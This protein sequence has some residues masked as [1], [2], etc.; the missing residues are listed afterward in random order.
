MRIFC[1]MLTLEA[2]SCSI[3]WFATRDAF[4]ASLN[5]GA[6]D[7]I[8]TDFTLPKFDGL[9]A[10]HLADTNGQTSRSFFVSGHDGEEAPSKSLR[11]GQWI[12]VLK[13]RMSRLPAR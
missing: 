6:F 13:D 12:N 5:E 10:L 3:T 7:L 2:L 9:S 4:Q 8:V 1:E 11:Q